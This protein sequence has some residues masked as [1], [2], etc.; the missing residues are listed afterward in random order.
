[1]DWTALRRSLLASYD[2]PGL[3]RWLSIPAF[4]TAVHEFSKRAEDPE[5]NAAEL[6]RIV[7]ADN[8]L[9]SELL[10]QVNSSA[11]SLRHKASTAQRAISVLGFYRSKLVLLNAAAHIA[12]KSADLGSF[13]HEAFSIANLRRGLL[14]QMIAKSLD[15]DED[16]A[17]A[18]GMMSDCVLPVLVAHDSEFYKTCR[19]GASESNALRPLS[20]FEYN[21]FQF[22]HAYAAAQVC[23]GWKFPD[24]LICCILLHHAPTRKL[25]KLGLNGSAVVAVKIAAYLPDP[26]EQQPGGVQ[27][28]EKIARHL[29]GVDL[30]DLLRQVDSTILNFYPQCSAVDKLES[31]LTEESVASA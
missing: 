18:G 27:A 31:L 8:G 30:V 6:G 23:V 11:V 2:S 21:R 22:C 26:F 16:L 29:P 15:A 3:P 5:A 20:Y 12:L 13:D 9:T 1:M 17:F 10:R 4:P 24:D 25:I 28:L 19:N 7:E 14:A